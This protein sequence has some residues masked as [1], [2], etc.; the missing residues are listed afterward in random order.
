MDTI[1][2]IGMF[3]ASD[4]AYY[5]ELGF[6]VVALEA[7]PSARRARSASASVAGFVGAAGLS[8]SHNIAGWIVGQILCS[9][10]PILVQVFIFGGRVEHKRPAG[11]LTVLGATIG[12]LL[13]EYGIPRF[14]KVDIEGADRY[15]ILPLTE[16]TRPAYLSFEVGE[17]FEELLNHAENIGYCAFKI[18]NQNTFRESANLNRFRDRLVRKLAYWMGYAEPLKIRRAGR[19]FVCGHSSGPVPW[20]SD[21]EWHSADYVRSILRGPSLPGW[22][23]IHAS[24]ID[25]A[26][27]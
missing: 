9:A 27:S 15:C 5:L 12:E 8:Q 25:R 26:Q 4:T 19:F 17:D 21:G 13:H 18:I 7:N 1:F 6:R 20:L 24:A 14:I 22:N 3:D 10:Q 2:D 16:S 23:D 11:S